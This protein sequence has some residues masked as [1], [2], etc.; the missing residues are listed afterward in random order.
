MNNSI[1]KETVT[2]MTGKIIYDKTNTTLIE[3]PY[4]HNIGYGY[5]PGGNFSMGDQSTMCC[6]P[7]IETIVIPIVFS[8]VVVLGCIG[9]TLVI[10]VIL[11]NKTHF[12]NT[13][14]I[15]ILNLSMA[16]MLFLIFCVP[17]HATIYTVPDWP[18]GQ[19]MCKFVHFVQFASMVA[20]VFTL[21]MM[22]FDR[23]LAVAYPIRTK[24]IRRPGIA[25]VVSIFIWVFSTAMAMPW[26]VFYTVR[27]Y[28]EF[29]PLPLAICADDWGEAWDDRPTYFLVLFIIGYAIPLIMIFI[30][31][32]LMLYQLWTR[33]GPRGS[34]S[35]ETC[36]AR[37]KVT[38]L[39]IVVVVVFSVCWLPSHVMWLW[40]NYFIATFRRTYA[41][42]YAR[43]FAHVLSYANSSMNPIIYAFL[44]ENFRK[45]FHK[46]IRCT[47][48]KITPS[49]HIATRT[50]YSVTQ[51]EQFDRRRSSSNSAE[52]TL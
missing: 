36:R 20:S 16:D 3:G 25:L 29:G 14:N 35:A 13:T 51:Y 6:I 47:V 21:V 40:S 11:K 38:R 42:Y 8:L 28:R 44:S 1:S 23:Y 37:G 30:M 18:F 27:V 46:A 33:R 19:F 50:V 22:A 49:N 10:V 4:F 34:F 2:E 45:Y 43:I 48:N 7:G 31:S 5:F 41:F 12:R 9:N 17:F 52:N 26:P 32:A 15:F 24:H 39:V